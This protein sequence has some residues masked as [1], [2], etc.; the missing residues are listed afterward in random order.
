[1]AVSTAALPRRLRDDRSESAT[2]LEGTE[3]R[4]LTRRVL[5]ALV[6]LLI[7]GLAVYLWP[8]RFGGS[9]RL[10]IVSGQSM[11]PTYDLG[12]IVIA[13]DGTDYGVGDIVVFAVPEG[14]AKG[15]LVIHR[16]VGVDDNGNFAT[17]GDNRESPDQ[18]L[19]TKD[20]IVGTPLVHIPKG[21][22]LVRAVQQWYV[23]AVILGLLA[24]VLVWPRSSEEDDNDDE[25]ELDPALLDV[26]VPFDAQLVRA[27][28]PVE[29]A[30]PLPPRLVAAEVPTTWRV[31]EW[32]D[33]EIPDTVMAEAEAW[34]EQE[35][36]R[37]LSP[38]AR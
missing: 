11:E 12:D 37:E 26:E 34:L 10:V 30:E 19:L 14:E 16:I 33:S 3:R 38:A 23:L 32:S 21:G 29:I 7:V 5:S 28:V 15:L 13:R 2:A 25:D 18:W 22:L 31:G 24:I 8:A 9:T 6:T 4:S 27:L 1:V 17:Q 20:D 36:E 35:L